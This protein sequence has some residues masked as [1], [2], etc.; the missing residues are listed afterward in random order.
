MIGIAN[1]MA[2][3][4]F[5]R[6]LRLSA[7]SN[8][9]AFHPKNVDYHLIGSLT[10]L[11]SHFHLS[12]LN[13]PDETYSVVNDT[14]MVYQPV[15]RLSKTKGKI[16]VSI[17]VGSRYV[18]VTT[19]S[20][21][22]IVTGLR[23]NAT[24]NDIF[25][26]SEVDEAPTS[27]QTEDDSAFGLRTENLK[28]VMFFTSPRRQEILQSIRSAKYKYGTEA[29]I[30][31]LPERHVRPQDVPGTLLNIAL[32]NMS[33]PDQVLRL[34]SYNL[35]AA[36]CRAFNFDVDAHFLSTTGWWSL[37]QSVSVT[38]CVNLISLQTS[39]CQRIPHALSWI[40]AKRSLVQSLILQWIFSTNSSLAGIAFL[41]S[42]AL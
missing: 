30:S 33:S 13:L 10:D 12:Q 16:D 9:S 34:A 40:S 29:K 15:T 8:H 20:K 27:I 17:K 14:R 21:Q 35:L 25:R 23:L 7:K 5:R 41:I 32:A 4:C 31:K 37:L 18:Q 24:I 11:Q 39:S 36:L 2:R 6:V 26:L 42:N 22:E 3:K 1:F 28:I 38:I 19:N